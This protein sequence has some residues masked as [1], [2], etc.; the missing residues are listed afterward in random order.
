VKIK[1]GSEKRPRKDFPYYKVQYL[2]NPVFGWKDY[3]KSFQ[4]R[5]EA[6]SFMS[7]KKKGSKFDHRIMIVESTRKRYPLI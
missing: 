4:E 1:R 7:E 6:D 2:E 3:T 5:K